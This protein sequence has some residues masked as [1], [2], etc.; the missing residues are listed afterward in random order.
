[1]SRHRSHFSAS[2]AGVVAMAACA[3]ANDPELLAS[4]ATYV[5]VS[6]DGDPLPVELPSVGGITHVFL[7]SSAVDFA[8]DETATRVEKL[9]TVNSATGKETTATTRM[10]YDVRVGADTV[11]LLP[12]CTVPQAACIAPTYLV[13]DGSRY[14]LTISYEPLRTMTLVKQ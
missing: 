10:R 8:V 3:S 13:R 12:R 5:A 11:T 6:V 9:R 1:M 2:L 14:T 4:V 7:Q